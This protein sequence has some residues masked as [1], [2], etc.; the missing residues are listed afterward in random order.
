[1]ELEEGSR[2]ML[3][4]SKALPVNAVPEKTPKGLLHQK[5]AKF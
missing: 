2:D 3:D 1:M 4:I 5:R